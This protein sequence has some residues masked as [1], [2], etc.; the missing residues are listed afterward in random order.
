MLDFVIL[1]LLIVLRD[2]DVRSPRHRRCVGFGS[3]DLRRSDGLAPIRKR[4]HSP[5]N[6][7]E[8]GICGSEGIFSNK[9][10]H[11]SSTIQCA[12]SWPSSAATQDL[13][14]IHQGIVWR[15][16]FDFYGSWAV[17]DAIRET[18]GRWPEAP[19]HGEGT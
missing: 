8:F 3:D 10:S 9:L 17:E 18:P 12:G 14:R 4:A 2:W 7:F 16:D 15:D 1:R 11:V 13:E 6:R 5:R 19:I